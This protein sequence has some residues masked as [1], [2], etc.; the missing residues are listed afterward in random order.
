MPRFNILVSS[1]VSRSPRTRQLEAMFDVPPSEKATLRWDGEIPVDDKPWNVG[2]IVGPSGCGKSTILRQAF[3][4]E[5]QFEWGAPSVIDDFGEGISIGDI[6]AV[7]QAVGFNTIPAWMR[8]YAALSNGERFRVELA[9]RLLESKQ[10]PIIVDEFTSVVDRQVA[11]IGAHA[12]QKYVRRHGKRFVAAS[13]HSDIVEWLQPDWIF[14][15]ATM[16]YTPRGCLQRR[17]EL[18][19]TISRIPHAAWSLFSPYHYMSA[20]LHKA[21]TCFGLWVGD[22]LAAFAGMLYRPHPTARDVWGC[23]RL[24]TLPDWQ[25]LGLA[26]VLIDTIG[27][28]YKALGRRVSTYPAHPALIRTFAKSP[29]WTQTKKAGVFNPVSRKTSTLSSHKNTMGTRPNAT[30]SYV[31]GSMATPDARRLVE[32]YA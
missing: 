25:G 19:C 2:L 15:P 10:S 23:S 18:E 30:F 9:R 14:E 28:A 17:P 3:G 6:S 21:A 27:S 5:E 11:Q 32:M 24:V 20:S 8:P 31:G 29:R 1:D 26:M 16:K 22:R 12:V 4:A 7:C 13:C